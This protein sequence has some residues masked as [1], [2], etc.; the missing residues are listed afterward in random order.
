MSTPRKCRTRCAARRGGAYDSQSDIARLLRVVVS[1]LYHHRDVFLRELI[2]NSGDA[3]EK[4]RFQSLTDRSVLDAAPELNITLRA[5]QDPPRLVLTDSGVGMTREE[6]QRNLGTIARSGTSDFV[7]KLEGSGDK[8]TST[9]LIGQFGLG[10]YSSFLVADRV[11]VASKSNSDSTQ[12]VFES[13]ADAQSFSIR[14]D[15]RGNTLG[16]G[17]EITLCVGCLYRS[18]T[19]AATSSQTAPSTQR[20]LGFAN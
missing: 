3:L 12:W 13:A 6:L 8:A 15:Q 2:S 10:F 9:N 17:T 11:G 7:D 16:R 20:R 4:L 14:E 1:H 5:Y 19:H 18:V